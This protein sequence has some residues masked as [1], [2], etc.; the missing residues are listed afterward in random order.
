MTNAGSAQEMKNGESARLEDVAAKV[1][2]IQPG[3]WRL[4][5]ELCAGVLM[6]GEAWWCYYRTSD[7]SVLFP[8]GGGCAFIALFFSDLSLRFRLKAL[9]YD[10]V[11]HG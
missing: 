4:V 9:L 8:L 11:L 5:S 3:H 1:R 6:L 10:I 7:H 2:R